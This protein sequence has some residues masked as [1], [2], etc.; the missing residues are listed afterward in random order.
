MDKKKKY[1][2]LTESQLRTLYAHYFQFIQTAEDSLNSD[3]VDE[4]IIASLLSQSG[5]WGEL[6]TLSYLDVTT[7]FMVLVGI[8]EDLHQAAIAEDPQEKI[9]SYL[10]NKWEPDTWK[11]KGLAKEH[12][13]LAITLF[14]AMRG[15]LDALRMFGVTLD[16]L[17]ARVV[18]GN[19][20]ALF[21]AVMVD[22]AAVQAEPIAQRICR[23]QLVNDCSFFDQLAKSITRTKPRRPNVELDDARF[24]AALLDD[25]GGLRELTEKD[26]QALFLDDLELYPD[27]RKDPAEA[28][29]KLIAKVKHVR[30]K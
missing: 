12:E 8:H 21:E 10:E 15:N 2:K 16:R 25:S 7:L 20:V 29:K 5:S 3:E 24:V 1:G 13:P 4:A 27:N 30:G 19:D 9:L 18:E 28:L 22:R 23:A 14:F 11:P 17:V 6:Y 26:L